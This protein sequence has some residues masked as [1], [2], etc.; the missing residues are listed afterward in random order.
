M[1][2][3]NTPNVEIPK[4][5]KEFYAEYEF[6]ETV[7]EN[8]TAPIDLMNVTEV[9]S[10]T[11]GVYNIV[12]N[13][14]M[15]NI[16]FNENERVAVASQDVAREIVTISYQ[17]SSM[18]YGG[19]VNSENDIMNSVISSP[20]DSGFDNKNSSHEFGNVSFIMRDNIDDYLS[21]RKLLTK[22]TIL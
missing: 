3:D 2:A 4:K 21:D 19:P 12:Y 9:M 20:S 7:E 18:L 14:D 22:E 6:V 8:S 15:K 10:K 1:F 13:M 17:N 16:I 11:N 5:E